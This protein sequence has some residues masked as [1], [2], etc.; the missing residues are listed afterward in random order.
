MHIFCIIYIFYS[1]PFAIN[2]SFLLKNYRVFTSTKLKLWHMQVTLNRPQST[3]FNKVVKPL[4][5]PTMS[6]ALSVIIEITLFNSIKLMIKVFTRQS[7]RSL[8]FV[9]FCSSISNTTLL[10]VLDS[11]IEKLHSYYKFIFILN[12]LRTINH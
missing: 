9:W 12:I 2:R 7:N 5:R 11:L 10:I 8:D 1:R 4:S 6:L 3:F